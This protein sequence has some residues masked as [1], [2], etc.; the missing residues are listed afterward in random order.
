MTS[1]FGINR[2]PAEDAFWR[3]VYTVLKTTHSVLYTCGYSLIVG[4]RETI[5]HV[6]PSMVEALGKPRLVENYEQI[7]EYL[8]R[9]N[10][11]ALSPVI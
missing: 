10:S 1:G 4:Q 6:I 2:P 11:G 3:S 8:C 7:P 9:R 5:P